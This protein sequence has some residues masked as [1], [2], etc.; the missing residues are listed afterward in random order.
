MIT[1]TTNKNT[2]QLQEESNNNLSELKLGEVATI[3]GID[4]DCD[5]N[6]RERLLDLGFVKGADVCVQNISPLGDPIAYNI[7]ET[8]IAIRKEDAR[9]IEIIKRRA[10]IKC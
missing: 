5:N 9:Y 8:L 10:I 4:K 7:H 6:I 2:N 3:C 1:E